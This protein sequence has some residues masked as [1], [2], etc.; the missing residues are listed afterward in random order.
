MSEKNATQPLPQSVTVGSSN[1]PPS[2]Y[3]RSTLR[4][5]PAMHRITCSWLVVDLRTRLLQSIEI[6]GD[7]GYTPIVVQKE[8]SCDERI[9]FS[10]KVK[11]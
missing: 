5:E 2:P 4:R 1:S 7:N 8:D 6:L 11:P 10:V 3:P 9:A